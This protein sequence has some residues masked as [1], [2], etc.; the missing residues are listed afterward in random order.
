MEYCCSIRGKSINITIILANIEIT[1]SFNAV[2]L[3]SNLQ[4]KPNIFLNCNSKKALKLPLILS[5][6][7]LAMLI[8]LI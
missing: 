6:I 3:R 7:A 5:D 2:K 4:L 8:I 1:F